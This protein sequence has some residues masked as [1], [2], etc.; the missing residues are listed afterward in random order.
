[1]LRGNK[2]PVCYQFSHP[3]VVRLADNGDG[4][5]AM[6]AVWWTCDQEYLDQCRTTL[7]YFKQNVT[8]GKAQ[9]IRS[10]V[11]VADSYAMLG[12]PEDIVPRL[13]RLIEERVARTPW[14]PACQKPM[15]LVSA[16]SDNTYAKLRHVVFVCDC[17]RASDQLVQ[18]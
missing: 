14:C 10:V 16:N 11:A 15:H 3:V 7:S 2:F 9:V 13:A 6:P 4:D 17:G 1:M 8:E 5:M 18:V 12:R